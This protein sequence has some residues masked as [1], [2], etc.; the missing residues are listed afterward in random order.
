VAGPANRIIERVSS[1]QY[2]RSYFD[3]WYRSPRAVVKP[4]AVQ[5][6]AR[7]ALAAAEYVLGRPVRSV[8]DVGCGE[9]PWR[10]ILRRLRPELRYVGVDSS[11]YVVRRHGVRRNIRHGSLGTLDQ[12]ALGRGFDLVVCA[13]VLE[14]VPSP[15]VEAGLHHLRTLCRGL[16]YIEAFTS[17]DDMV[18]DRTGWHHRSERRYRSAFAAAGFTAC[19]LHCWVPTESRHLVS[20]MERCP[21]P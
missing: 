21:S 14:Y 3:R 1:K 5:R 19:G 15:E 16:A 18:G 17:G 6:K 2:D 4:E 12:L 9:A 11:E 7:L 13:D 10:A 8:L 20:A